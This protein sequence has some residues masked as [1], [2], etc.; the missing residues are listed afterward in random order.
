MQV[1]P[2]LSV[3]KIVEIGHQAADKAVDR[4]VQADRGFFQ[5]GKI[6]H[7]V[8]GA[9][10]EHLTLAHFIGLSQKIRQAAALDHQVNGVLVEG[11]GC[12]RGQ[13]SVHRLG[14]V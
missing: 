8:V 4:L 1:Q 7:H 3:F 5:G 11:Q 2:G 12:S 13:Q 14:M 9:G 10:N 6:G